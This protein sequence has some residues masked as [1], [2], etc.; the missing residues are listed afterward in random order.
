M[1]FLATAM[2]LAMSTW[3]AAAA[4][5]SELRAEFDLSRTEGSWLTIA[6]Q[7][8]FVVGAVGSAVANLADL[9]PPRRLVL[10]GSTVAAVANLTLLVAPDLPSAMVGRAVTGAGLALVYPP[11]LKAASTW[12]RRR[13]GLALGVLVGAL[14]LG[15]ALPHLVAA[16]G[17]IGWEETIVATSA[18]TLAGGLVA[19]FV[20]RDGPFEFATAVFDRRRILTVFRQQELRLATL[21]Y[22]GHMWELYAMWTWFGVF[23]TDLLRDRGTD[24]AAQWASVATFFVV[25][26]GAIGSWLGGVISDRR[27]RE[28]AAGSALALSGAVATVIGFLADAHPLLVLALGL[29]WGFWVVADSA[30]FSTIVSERADE[31]SV[32]TALTTQL[33]SGFVLTVFTIFLVPVVEEAVG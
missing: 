8:G 12:F 26:A 2:V 27:G 18:L 5:L 21:G 32:G 14:T 13:R 17:G 10:I 3:F 9:I 33:A 6:V 30:Q 24:D 22:F 23:Y 31:D 20:A 11:G 1:A 4:V 16:L 7:I 29:F 15:S 28:L 25:G 19:E